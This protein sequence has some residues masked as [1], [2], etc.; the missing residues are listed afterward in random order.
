MTAGMGTHFGSTTNG[1]FLL[2]IKDQISTLVNSNQV[3]SAINFVLDVTKRNLSLRLS[4]RTHLIGAIR[5]SGLND[6]ETLVQK[7][8][9]SIA[10]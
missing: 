5:S 1:S 2:K 8:R 4:Y 7:V 10:C 9:D 6:K 3:D